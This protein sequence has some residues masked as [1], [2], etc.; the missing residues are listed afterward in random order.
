MKQNIP[1]KD[2]I[3]TLIGIARA[4]EARN[5]QKK[6]HC[7]RVA[8]VARGIGLKLGMD[9]EVLARLQIMAKLENIGT[10]GIR[11]DILSKSEALSNEE[12]EHIHSHTTLG[13]VLLRPLKMLEDVADVIL[14][15]HE[16]WDGSGY[17]NG[18]S[19]EDIPLAS[20]IIGVADTYCALISARPYRD[21][22][23]EPVAADII[24]EESGAR[25]SP[26]VVDG[27]MQWYKANEGRIE[28]T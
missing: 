27:F 2:V 3:D 5:Y 17:P 26:E 9:E 12:F 13:A 24:K 10:V 15:H 14:T 28:P 20:R 4:A 8:L 1:A 16:R 18:I 25:F 6:D 22:L 19:G 7:S 23:P 21:S 11:D